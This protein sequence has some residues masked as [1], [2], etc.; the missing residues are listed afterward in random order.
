MLVTD[1]LKDLVLRRAPT[2]EISRAAEESGMTRL[3][4][5]GLFKAA[6]GIT[7]IEEVL[8]TVV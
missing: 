4:D 3:K 7:T 6:R 5:D 8:R 1:D 2:T